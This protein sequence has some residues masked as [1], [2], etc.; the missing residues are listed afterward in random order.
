MIVT[1]TGNCCGNCQE[2]Q[3]NV[4]CPPG[5]L[6][7]VRQVCIGHSAN[8]LIARLA[9]HMLVSRLAIVGDPSHAY[10]VLRRTK[11]S[12]MYHISICVV[13]EL[14]VLTSGAPGTNFKLTLAYQR[15]S[16]HL[17]FCNIT[18]TQHLM[19]CST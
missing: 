8:S 17:R 5:P 11:N 19:D 9:L 16:L 6:L 3:G 18:F 12:H 14:K 15:L 10:A 2:G 4:D 7:V 1:S 13:L